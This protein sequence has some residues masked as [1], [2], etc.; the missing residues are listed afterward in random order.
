M[1]WT[2]KASDCY[3]AEVQ[4]W[5]WH[6]TLSAGSVVT[7][8]STPV[9]L[10]WGTGTTIRGCKIV[11]HTNKGCFQRMSVNSIKNKHNTSNA[12]IMGSF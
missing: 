10:C 5:G 4:Q 6:N 9:S 2:D 12:N 8:V 7:F 3:Y 1:L 11:N